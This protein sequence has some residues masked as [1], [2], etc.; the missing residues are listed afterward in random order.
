LAIGFM[1]VQ[2]Y[3]LDHLF[4][5]RLEA[6]LRPGR[7]P[8]EKFI[9]ICSLEGRQKA[10]RAFDGSAALGFLPQV[11]CGLSP[12]PV[13]REKREADSPFQIDLEIPSW[14]WE[15]H[16]DNPCHEHINMAQNN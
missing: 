14:K 13:G 8:I 2:I 5:V 11:T 10:K 16:L 12:A 6:L 9:E 7:I 3:L 4:G 1:P 15:N